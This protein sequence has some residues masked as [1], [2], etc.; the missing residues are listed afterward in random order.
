[1]GDLHNLRN[2]PDAL[3]KSI[4]EPVS[5]LS[6]YFIGTDA[7]A[8]V[9]TSDKEYLVNAETGK[10]ISPLAKSDATKLLSGITGIRPSRVDYVT[11]R[12]YEYKYGS[13]PA[14]RGEF[15]DGRIIHVSQQ[16]GEP[17]SWTDRQGMLI[18]ASYY[19]LHAFQFTDSG[20]LNASIGFFAIFWAIASVV[21]GLLLY[22]RKRKLLNAVVLIVACFS[23]NTEAVEQAKPLTKPAV[24]IVSLAPSCT[25][26]IAGLGFQKKLVGITE[27]TDYPPEVLNLPVVGS[28]VNLNLEAIVSLQPDLVIATD[29]G[30]PEP[31]IDRLR[32]LSIPVFVLN[33]RT[34]ENIQESIL[35]LGKFLGAESEAKAQVEK[36]SLVA[37]CIHEKTKNVR[38]PTI[39]FVY[40]SYPFVTAGSGTFTDQLIEMAGARSI[41]HDVKISYPR[42]TIENVLAKNPDVVIETSMDPRTEEKAKLKWWKQWPMLEAVKKNRIHVLDSRNLD[43]PSQRIVL[44]FLQ[45]AKTLHPELLPDGACVN[46]K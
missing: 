1:M 20:A 3:L 21:T 6:V 22:T 30:N 29:D 33:L 31:V 18:R 14:W 27:H 15:A 34:Y 28:Y 45:L 38:K 4:G 36:M 40:E 23:I 9:T 2:S 24:R 5:K 12:S 37:Q 35:S 26:I 7:Y 13:L 11:R 44:G 43:R 41:T 19:Y 16:T 8:R 46:E 25:E 17:Q 32:E 42:L 39:L 10:V